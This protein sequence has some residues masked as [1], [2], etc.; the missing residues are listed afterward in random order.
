MVSDTPSPT[1]CDVDDYRPLS[2][3]DLCP[4][5]YTSIERVTQLD[6]AQTLI[7]LLIA[8]WVAGGAAVAVVMR[9]SGH[10]FGL[11]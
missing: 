2:P 4:V 5:D 10:D 6:S 8:T 11:G 9:R 1:T 7:A 3:P